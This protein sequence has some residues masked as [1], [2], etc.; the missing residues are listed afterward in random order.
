MTFFKLE[1]AFGLT[2]TGKHAERYLQA[3]LTQDIKKI[4]L[5]G[6]ALAAALSPQGKAEGIFCVKK[7]ASDSFH[8]VSFAG[9]QPTIMA[10]FLRYKV[11]DQ[12]E[13]LITDGGVTSFWIVTNPHHDLRIEQ[14]S[15]EIPH[16]AHKALLYC[17]NKSFH[18]TDVGS[19]KDFY[20][21]R[22]NAMLPLL[23][24]EVKSGELFPEKALSWYV[25]H[26]KG[27]YTGQEVLEKIDSHGQAPFTLARVTIKTKGALLQQTA[28]YNGTKKAGVILSFTQAE[29]GLYHGF[30]QV[31]SSTPVNELGVEGIDALVSEYVT[32]T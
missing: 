11:A 31:R 16:E 3:R 15:F 32:E 1:N 26:T 21:Y 22:L 25:S 24:T 14:Y 18:P 29:E 5:N 30:V 27:C 12:F 10:A 6:T 23:D 4:P 28:L 19:E 2:V 7:L 9:D 20:L 17:T 8:L 13:T